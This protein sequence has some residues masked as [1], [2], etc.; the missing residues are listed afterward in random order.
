[1]RC[2]VDRDA[3]AYQDTHAAARGDTDLLADACPT[4]RNSHGDGNIDSDADAD[5]DRDSHANAYTYA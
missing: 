2:T 3:H 5:T 1:M 4:Y